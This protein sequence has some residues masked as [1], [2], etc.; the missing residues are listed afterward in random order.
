MP[1]AL[2]VKNLRGGTLKKL[3]PVDWIALILVIVGGLNWGLVG[4]FQFDL[5]QAILGAIPVLARI[6]YVLVG[7]A[8][9]Y[10]IYYL[11]QASK[12]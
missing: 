1:R 8:G 7:L 4:A 5:V 11:V 6:V 12:A 9:L 10:T 3:N 2:S